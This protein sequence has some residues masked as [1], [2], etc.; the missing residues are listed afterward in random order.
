MKMANTVDDVLSGKYPAK[1]HAK[2]VIQCMKEQVG[3]V[4]GLLYLEGQKSRMIEVISSPDYW[5]FPKQ[6]SSQACA[7][8]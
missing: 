8:G 2:K 5:K 4:S 3:E 6:R 1:L 7:V